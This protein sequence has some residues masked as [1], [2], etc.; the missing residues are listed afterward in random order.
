M[1]E[2]VKEEKEVTEENVEENKLSPSDYSCEILL[3]KTNL[4]NANDKKFPSDAYLVWYNV[5]GNEMLD[6]TRSSK[7]SNIFDM[8]YDRYK[9]DLKRIEWGTG[10]TT[11]SMWGYSQTDKKKKK[12]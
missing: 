3:S 2:G 8:Y 5:D 4:E 6:L 11:P 12:K 7:R 10:T 1:T 9:K